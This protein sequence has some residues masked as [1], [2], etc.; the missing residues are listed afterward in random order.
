[1]YESAAAAV[2]DLKKRGFSLERENTAEPGLT[3]KR[4]KNTWQRGAKA[5]GAST[6]SHQERIKERLC[7]FQR[8]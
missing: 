8:L 7:S 1:M 2:E 6:Q 5:A 4:Q 3:E